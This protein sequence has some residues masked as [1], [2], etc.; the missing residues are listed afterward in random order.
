[1]M[2]L[3]EEEGLECEIHADGM[4]LEH[5]SEFKYLGSILDE[6]G[7]YEAECRKKAT[8]GRCY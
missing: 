2:M 8:S 3:N 6:S 5:V 7:T 4:Q 1:M